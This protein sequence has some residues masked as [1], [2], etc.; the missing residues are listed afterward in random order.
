MRT[1]VLWDDAGQAELLGL[2]LGTESNEVRICLSVE[3]LQAQRRQATDVILMS[4]TFPKTADEGFANFM[5]LQETMSSAPVVLA[6][7]PT[8]MLS[9]PRFMTKGLRHYIVRDD[10]GDFMFLALTSLEGAVAAARAE[11][12]KK[13]ASLLRE[14]MDGVR[15]MQETIIPRGLQP[16]PGYA[17]TA[18]YEPAQVQVVGEQPVVMAGGD[19]YDLFRPDD[20]FLTL[21]V[22]DASGHGLKAC[23]SI[24]AMHTLIRMFTGHRYRETASFVAEI[25][26]RLCDNAIVQS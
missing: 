2:Y 9:L 23:M 3:E 18:R 4:L 19:Y 17:L 8:E 10:N 11:E 22:G 26:Q 12:A 20:K 6:C 13:L 1:L 5:Q 24:M 16:P 25:N 7:R 14:E 21:L 15:R